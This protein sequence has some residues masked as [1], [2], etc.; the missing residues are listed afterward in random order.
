MHGFV[1]VFPI[2]WLWVLQMC[3]LD[4]WFGFVSGSGWPKL[5][6]KTCWVVFPLQTLWWLGWVLFMCDFVYVFHSCWVWGWSS[7]AWMSGLGLS[8]GLAGQSC[9]LLM[10]GGFPLANVVVVGLGFVRV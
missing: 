10:L 6:L 4:D 7:V 2:G 8:L 1:C 5:R 9:G 3:W